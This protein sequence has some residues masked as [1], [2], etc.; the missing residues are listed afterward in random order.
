MVP[1][2][3]KAAFTQKIGEVGEVV[4]TQFGYHLIKVTKKTK[5]GQ[6]KFEEVKEEIIQKITGPKGQKTMQNYIAGLESK[7]NI[8]RSSAIKPEEIPTP[9]KP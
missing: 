4:E 2:F 6:R 1:A 8:T 5:S 9:K 3:E 7:A